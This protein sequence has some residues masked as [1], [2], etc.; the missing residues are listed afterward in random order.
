MNKNDNPKIIPIDWV[1]KTDKYALVPGYEFNRMTRR[2]KKLYR[3]KGNCYFTNG[4]P[5][6]LI[7][8]IYRA[9]LKL[10]LGKEKLIFSKGSIKI[11]KRPVLSAIAI[12][13]LD[14][15]AGTSIKIPQR[16]KYDKTITLLIDY[17]EYKLRLMELIVL[18]GL[19]QL[20]RPHKKPSWY[21]DMAAAIIAKGWLQI[22]IGV[23]VVSLVNNKP[24]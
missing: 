10:S 24:R 13:K 2:I 20:A 5:G 18:R 19:L 3:S 12:Y 14:W 16:L 7:D 21:A 4:I 15:D 17:K 22:D 6:G 8:F 11:N 23:P 9:V 1:K